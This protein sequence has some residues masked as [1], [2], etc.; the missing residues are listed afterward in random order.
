MTNE[1]QAATIKALL[2]ERRAYEVRGLASRVADVDEALARLGYEAAK[3]V[4][5]AIARPA[6]RRPT[7]R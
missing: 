2:D 3:P 6:Q 7:R 4:E 1:E 5:R